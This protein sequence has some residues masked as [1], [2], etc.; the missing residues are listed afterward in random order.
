[1]IYQFK[2][3]KMIAKAYDIRYINQNIQDDRQLRI[4][5]KMKMKEATE[6]N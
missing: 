2:V 6:S 4:Y 3:T 5:Y 1:M